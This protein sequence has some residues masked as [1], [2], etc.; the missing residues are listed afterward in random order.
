MS[1]LGAPTTVTGASR[2][3]PAQSAV[4]SGT[5]NSGSGIRVLTAHGAGG[6]GRPETPVV[7]LSVP[8]TGSSASAERESGG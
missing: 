3:M 8:G 4:V 5:E 6:T 7:M 2:V 1:T